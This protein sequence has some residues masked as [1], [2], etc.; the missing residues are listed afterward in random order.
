[1]DDNNSDYE[2]NKK[3]HTKNNASD[4][5]DIV[6]VNKKQNLIEAKNKMPLN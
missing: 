1:M 4:L 6:D 2:Y 3:T 5:I